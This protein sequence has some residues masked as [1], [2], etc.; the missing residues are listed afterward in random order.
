MGVVLDGPSLTSIVWNCVALDEDPTVMLKSARMWM[1]F[2]GSDGGL[3]G[4]VKC[5]RV[6]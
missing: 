5:G 1:V 3:Q 4:S 6:R 2:A